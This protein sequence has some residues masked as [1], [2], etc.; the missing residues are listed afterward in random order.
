MVFPLLKS[1]SCT[2]LGIVSSHHKSSASGSYSLHEYDKSAGS[3][4]KSIGS[5]TVRSGGRKKSRGFQH[6]LSIPNDT[7]WG[8][9][10]AIVTK[11]QDGKKSDQGK[12]SEESRLT[13]LPEHGVG[14]SRQAGSRANGRLSSARLGPGE[15]VMTREWQVR[16]E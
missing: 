10:E 8:S 2:I 15:I 6:P 13:A 14:S 3:G 12:L 9:D 1:W 11:E 7:A 4:L 5:A 16:G